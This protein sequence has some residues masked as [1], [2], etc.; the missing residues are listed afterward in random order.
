MRGPTGVVRLGVATALAAST[1][2]VRAQ[3]VPP[4]VEIPS[5]TDAIN[6]TTDDDDGGDDAPGS[7]ALD[8]VI[9]TSV[10]SVSRKPQL[11]RESPGV[12]TVVTREEILATGARDLNDVLMLVPS[13][14]FAVDVQGVVGIGFRGN[15]AAEGKVL[16][17]VDGLELNE[18][19]YSG[20]EW[21]NHIPVDHI[22]RIEVIRGPGSSIYG[23]YAEMAVI[24]IVTRTGKELRG[25]SAS[26]AFGRFVGGSGAVARSN[27]G[28]ELGDHRDGVTWS[29]SGLLGRGSRS[30]LAYAPPP[31]PPGE[32]GVPAFSLEDSARLDPTYLAGSISWRGLT[33]RGLYD[34]FHSTNRDG[35]GVAS[36]AANDLDFTGYFADLQYERRVS[37]RLTITPRLSYKR[38][39]PWRDGDVASDY[40]YDKT[41]ERILGS[42]TASWDPRDDLNVLAGAEGFRDQAKLNSDQLVGLQ[43]AFG[44]DGATSISYV[45][46]AGFAQGTLSHRLANL[47]VGSRVENHS[48]FGLSFV[49]RIGLTRVAG[50]FHVKLLAAR[51][52]RAPAIENINTNPMLTPERTTVLEVETGYQLA[53]NALVSINLFDIT[54]G[55]PIVFT[56]EGE[57]EAYLN[58]D[59][60]GSRGGEVDLKVRGSRGF[61]VA[62]ASAYTAQGK[63]R[64]DLYEVPGEQHAVLG[65][66]VLKLTGAASLAIWRGLSVGPSLVVMSRRYGVEPDD[67]E[68]LQVVSQAPALL[69]NGFVRYA[70][71]GVKGLELGVGVYNAL[72]VDYRF[73]QPYAGGH[74]SLPAP[75]RELFARLGFEMGFR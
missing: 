17:L 16:F 27:L 49:P 65:L 61:V 26:V 20:V 48:Q 43:S 46:V 21:S 38:Q 1:G 32:P 70:D 35:F 42:V 72:N 15:W 34:G 54:I 47:T 24:N 10:Y 44:E 56:V 18:R 2:I 14:S 7:L 31:P 9:R 8:D 30:D 50:R 6:K 51:A 37:N 36:P 25:A 29:V 13:I 62:S 52:F 60:A 53:D 11:V 58:Q 59:Q 73:V 63:N 22:E 55:D 57:D 64:V 41:A 3:G 68:T 45:N 23:G 74:P 4:E 40:H 5:Y 28:I 39:L 75:S 67:L 71:L 19:L 69:V 66:P 12:V 33:V